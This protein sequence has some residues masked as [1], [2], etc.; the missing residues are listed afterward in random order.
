MGV[1]HAVLKRRAARNG[2]TAADYEQRDTV[3]SL[4]MGV[5]SLVTPLV[6]P[7]LLRPFIPGKGRFG[8]ALVGAAVGA[9]VGTTV[10]DVVA[11]RAERRNDRDRARVARRVASAGGV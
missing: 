7:K 9:V 1:E 5:A 2:P 11:R 10:A 4:A 3:A 6:V 8:K